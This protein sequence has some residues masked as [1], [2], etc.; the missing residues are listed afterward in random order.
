MPLYDLIYATLY[1]W[2]TKTVNTEFIELRPLMVMT[3]IW[4][5]N[6]LTIGIAAGMLDYF[7]SFTYTMILGWVLII[8][9][10]VIHYFI[11]LRNRRDL[12]IMEKYEGLSDK[13][14]SLGS[15]VT[16]LFCVEGVLVLLA[17]AFIFM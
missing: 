8:L 17:Y 12:V 11:F 15:F 2:F 10:V 5:T 16:I 9:L 1:R 13:M 3:L 14:K 6:L 4:I 7:T